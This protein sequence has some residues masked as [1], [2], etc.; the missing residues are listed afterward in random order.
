[1][2]AALFTLLF[3]S[4]GE[5]FPEYGTALAPTVVT[6]NW[7]YFTVATGTAYTVPANAAITFDGTNWITANGTTPAGA[8]RWKVR[9]LASA[10]YETL[11]TY[12]PTLGGVNWP[13]AVTTMADPLSLVPEFAEE[14]G[15]LWKQEDGT[16]AYQEG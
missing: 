14:D 9:G 1:M 4:Y 8:K 11:L 10:D 16:Q 15:T 6:S 2:N 12:T 5:F 13:F 7:A 3:G